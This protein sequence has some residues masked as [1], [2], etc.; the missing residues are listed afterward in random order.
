MMPAAALVATTVNA[1]TC[2][3]KHVHHGQTS[4][5]LSST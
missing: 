5:T 3:R 4:T 2:K 1:C